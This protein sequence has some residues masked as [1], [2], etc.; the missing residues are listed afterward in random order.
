M[1]RWEMFK[2]SGHRGSISEFDRASGPPDAPILPTHPLDTS[3]RPASNRCSGN[4]GEVA[5]GQ[6]NA[7]LGNLG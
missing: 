4:P 1:S 6:V 2:E 5:D 3:I 7:Y